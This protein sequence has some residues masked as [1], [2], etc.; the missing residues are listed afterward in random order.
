MI[1]ISETLKKNKEAYQNISFDEIIKKFV[2]PGELLT[3][4]LYCQKNLK[5]FFKIHN[6]LTGNMFEFEQVSIQFKF[7]YLKKLE[8]SSFVQGF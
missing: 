5:S 6:L 7:R 8:A 3:D 1:S 4:L 2:I